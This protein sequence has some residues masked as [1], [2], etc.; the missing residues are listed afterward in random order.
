[1]RINSI[2]LRAL[3]LTLVN[4]LRT[5]VGEYAFRPITVV[6][7]VTETADGIGECSALAAP[8][9]TEEY[10]A[11]AEAVLVEH[12]IPRLMRTVGTDLDVLSQLQVLNEV[13]GHP[14]AK[15][16]LEMALL[17]ASLREQGIA[18]GEFLGATKTSVFAGANLSIGSPDA[19]IAAA[20]I[21]VDG[22]YQ[23]L[24]VKIA[25]G[26]D[27]EVLTALGATFPQ[28]ALA[29]DANG[30][31]DPHNSEHRE[32]LRALDGLGL[33]LIEQPYGPDELSA[34]A[35]LVR[36]FET[37]IFLDESIV[38]MGALRVAI[39]LKACGGISVKPARV[40]GV[41]VASAMHDLCVDEGLHLAIGGM[42]ESG[43]G[44]AAALA[45]GALPGFDLP[46]DLGGSERYFSPDLTQAHEVHSGRIALPEG[47]GL[48]VSIREDVLDAHTVRVHRFPTP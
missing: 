42:L 20:Q 12:L 39:E 9:Y 22:G 37:P 3:D 36:D 15:A 8:T 21:A 28:V 41:L 10:A 27:L 24:K 25:P 1:M 29:V 19:V 31:Y 18:L 6:R 46:G 43:I 14:M 23:R 33:S 16:A 5:S 11:G 48:G 30:A 13:R 44:R 40:G 34:H 7:I 4:P 45:V 32:V 47:P 17:D 2:E 35:E 38:S 26:A